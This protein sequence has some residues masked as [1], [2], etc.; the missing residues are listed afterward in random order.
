MSKV[1]LRKYESVVVVRSD[2]GQDAMRRLH[3]KFL[4]LLEKHNGRLVRFEVWGK[5]RLAYT[6]RKCTK[7]VYLYYVYL[8]GE[9]FVEDMSRNF[10]INT[11]ILRYMSVLLETEI[12]PETYDF[13]SEE[14]IDKLPEQDDHGDRNRSTTGWDAEVAAEI[15][16]DLDDDDEE[17][18][19]DDEDDDEDQDLEDEDDVEEDD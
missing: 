17:D 18:D 8:A 1:L 5:R 10:R 2:I 15:A 4:E 11:G 9:D 6:I 3:E 7:G 13:E 14:H 12:D 16:A 19:E